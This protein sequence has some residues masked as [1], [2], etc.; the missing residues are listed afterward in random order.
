MA[1]GIVEQLEVIDVDHQKRQFAVVL[2]GLHPFEVEPALEAAPVGEA[3]QHVD[4]G[5][6]GQPVIGGDQFPLALAELRRHRVEGP[7]QRNKFRRQRLGAARTDQ[8]PWPKRFATDRIISIGWMMSFSRG[9]Q[10]AEQ[11]E[12]TDEAELQIGG[13]DI[14]IDRRRTP[15]LRRY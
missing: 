1:V 14:A 4:R 7:G 10:R 15:W 13:A 3:G 6:H 9:D 11:H 12:Q 8:S 2:L 5:D